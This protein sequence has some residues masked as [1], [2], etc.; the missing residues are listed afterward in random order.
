MVPTSFDEE[1]LVLDGPPDMSADECAMLSVWRGFLGDGN[2]VVISCW[3]PTKEELDEITRTGRV[4]L[5]VWGTTMPPVH[6]TGEKP[7]DPTPTPPQ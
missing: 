7:F 4:W 1:N 5:L 6:L 2:P 3:K